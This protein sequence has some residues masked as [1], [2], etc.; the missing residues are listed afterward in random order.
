MIKASEYCV[1]VFDGTHDTP[2]PAEFGYKLL[3]SKNILSGRLDKDNA[4]YISEED[5]HTINQRSQVKQWDILFSMIGTVGNVCLIADSTID[6]A[7]KNMGVFSCG[8]EYKAKWLYFYLQSPYAQ[9][10]I[11]NYLNGA[12]QKFLSLQMLRDFP[13]PAFTPLSKSIVDVIWNLDEKIQLNNAINAELEVLAKTIYDY[14]FLQFEFPNEEGLPYKSS[15]GRMVWSEELKR[16]IP[17]GWVAGTFKDFIHIGNGKDHKNLK[18]GTIP[19][20]GS[21][22]VMRHVNES[23]YEGESVLL[24][25]M[26]QHNEGY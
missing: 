12:V 16:E 6:F 21:G 5:Y 9:K 23:I 7:I 8:E 2:K 24:P 3:T 26:Y 19:V 14:W 25:R 17:E 22:G 13:V 1:N 15:G 20:Y 18:D 4:Y 11:S 10:I